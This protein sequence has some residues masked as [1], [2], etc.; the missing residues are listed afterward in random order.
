MKKKVLI[1]DDEE[2]TVQL[3]EF[4][5]EKGNLIPILAHSGVK[6]LEKAREERPDLILLDIMMPGMDGLE[7]CEEIKKDHHLKEIP[8][9][10]LTALGQETDV[11]RG[12]KLGAHGYIIKPFNPSDLLH[13]INLILSQK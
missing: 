2:S 1:V 5:L 10:F 8:I 3:I 6:A 11:E 4:I 12:L 13:Q 9:L 7:V